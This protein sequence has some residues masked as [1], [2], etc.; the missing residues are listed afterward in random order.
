MIGRK[1]WYV[2]LPAAAPREVRNFTYWPGQPDNKLSPV[3]LA[4]FLNN[5][6]KIIKTISLGLRDLVNNKK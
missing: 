5:L 3:L 1:A 4:Q 2:R 6:T